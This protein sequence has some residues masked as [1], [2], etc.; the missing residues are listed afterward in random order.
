MAKLTAAEIDIET[1]QMEIVV[2]ESVGRQLK[3]PQWGRWKRRGDSL[4]H[5]DYPPC[6]LEFRG[7]G[8]DE[9]DRSEYVEDISDEEGNRIGLAVKSLPK[10][11]RLLITAL[12]VAKVS[13]NQLAKINKTTRPNIDQMHNR[14]LGMLEGM[15]RA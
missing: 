4:R 9:S 6:L 13:V 1:T 11:Y 5:L 15:L 14:A 12:Y 10:P 3:L 2:A 8:S 7:R